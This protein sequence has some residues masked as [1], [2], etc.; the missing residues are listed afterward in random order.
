LVAA[1]AAAWQKRDFGGSGSSLAEGGGG[2]CVMDIMIYDDGLQERD[3][4]RK[5]KFD[6]FLYDTL[7]A[8]RSLLSA[9]SRR[10][11]LLPTNVFAVANK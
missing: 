11:N 9:L 5:E 3:K 4:L 8:K 7:H 1:E 2:G 10:V 6:Y